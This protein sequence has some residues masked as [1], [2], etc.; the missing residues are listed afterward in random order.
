MREAAALLPFCTEEEHGEILRI[1]SILLLAHLL[2]YSTGTD[3]FLLQNMKRDEQLS[4]VLSD[5]YIL[6]M[7]LEERLEQTLI[8]TMSSNQYGDSDNE[9]APLTDPDVDISLGALLDVLADLLSKR[10]VSRQQVD[11]LHLLAMIIHPYHAP[12]TVPKASN[13]FADSPAW[14]RATSL[15]GNYVGL[16]F[17]IHYGHRRQ[18]VELVREHLL[19]PEIRNEYS[20]SAS[21]LLIGALPHLRS[22]LRNFAVSAHSQRDAHTA[23]STV[24]SLA[25]Q[26]RNYRLFLKPDWDF[27]LHHMVD[28][29]DDYQCEGKCHCKNRIND[30]S[31]PAK[32]VKDNFEENQIF[33]YDFFCPHSARGEL[34]AEFILRSSRSRVDADEVFLAHV[35]ISLTEAIEWQ[36]DCWTQHP[37]EPLDEKDDKTNKIRAPCLL[38]SMLHAANT[39]FYLQSHDQKEMSDDDDDPYGTLIRSSIQLLRHSDRGIVTASASLLVHAFSN[40]KCNKIDK[41]VALLFATIKICINQN[42]T[43]FLVESL[44]SCASNQSPSFASALFKF[45]LD[46][47]AGEKPV[48]DDNDMPVNDDKGV[49]YR[50]MASV[51]LNCPVVAWNDCES[52]DK[53]VER[54]D[55]Q[56]QRRLHAASALLSSRLA[57]LFTEEKFIKSNGVLRKFLR[58]NSTSHWEIYQLALRALVTGNFGV[59]SDALQ[60]L[61]TCPMS[62]NSYIWISVIEKV[63][64]A[65]SSLSKQGAMGIPEATTA[66]LSAV[67]YLQNLGSFNSCW[68]EGGKFQL[69]FLLLRLD[70]LDL[71]TVL[72]QLT[73][74]MRL[75]GKGPS[76]YTR[77]FL[78]LRNAI[79]GFDALASRYRELGLQYGMFFRDGQS[80]TSLVILQSLSLLMV[81]AA[82]SVFLDLHAPRTA[83]KKSAEA[84]VIDFRHPMAS[85]LRRLD[86][87]IVQPMDSSVDPLVRAAALLELMDG[88]L[89]VPLPFPRDFFVPRP[90]LPPSL[91]IFAD[92]TRVFDLYDESLVMIEASPKMGFTFFADGRIPDVCL[93]RS[94]TPV[95]TTLLWFRLLYAGPLTDD[96]D[97]INNAKDSDFGA[98]ELE[99]KDLK[100]PDLSGCSPVS[101]SLSP[102]GLFFFFVDCPPLSDEGLYKLEV[103]LG[104]RDVRG[105]EWEIPIRNSSRYSTVRVSRSRSIV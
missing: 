43:G 67:S 81:S 42:N 94:G 28:D 54:T 3:Y 71:V 89:M 36:V 6:H 76:K 9:F 62:E 48:V 53:L 73:Q 70:F 105:I 88:V 41:Y 24:A 40:A 80:S 100:M 37:D 50:L 10:P 75:T 72:R 97:N 15:M 49:L 7:P 68:R 57:R 91:R 56:Q 31:Q 85:L 11:L 96:E 2:P 25:V 19:V 8:Q 5:Q 29:Q 22:S 1:V 38:A 87:L 35:T 47:I 45:I 60:S 26:T 61:F 18:V 99:I 34:L 93:A 30:N 63:A 86:E 4:S 77:S 51:A 90:S 13:V 58:S 46:G 101:S 102:N 39:L 27:L 92:P 65:E 59:A 12:D 104:G 17:Q 82:K 23:L 98:E 103:K 33:N 84:L 78:H 52:I 16:Q 44:A 95:W 79:R 21:P 64:T 55:L 32:D 20:V 14:L 83:N 69:R 66:L 74:E